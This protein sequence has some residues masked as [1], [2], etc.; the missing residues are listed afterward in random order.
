MDT[1]TVSR[2]RTLNKESANLRDLNQTNDGDGIVRRKRT[3]SGNSIKNN[4][5]KSTYSNQISKKMN[6]TTSKKPEVSNNDSVVTKSR[7][8]KIAQ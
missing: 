5:P 2:S 3:L 6:S 4:D 7:T 1:K 8:R